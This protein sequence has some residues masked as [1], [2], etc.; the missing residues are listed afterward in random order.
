LQQVI[1]ETTGSKSKQLACSRGVNVF[2][3]NAIVAFIM[4]SIMQFYGFGILGW[5]ILEQI[6]TNK[7]SN[8]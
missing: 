1:K 5:Y 4:H 8:N 7:N 2:A 3:A 6:A